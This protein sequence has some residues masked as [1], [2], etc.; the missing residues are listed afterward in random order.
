MKFRQLVAEKTSLP[1]GV[2]PSSYQ[3]I[4]NIMVMKFLKASEEEK[5]I[6]SSS[7]LELYPYIKTVCE[8]KGI[9]GEFRQPSVIKLAGNGTET[10]HKEHG[11]SYNL[12]VSKIMFSKGNHFERQ[13]IAKKAKKNEV[14][15]DMFAGIGYFSLGMKK[16]GKVYA[17][18]KNPVAFNYLQQN[19]RINKISNVEAINKDCREVNLDGIADRIIMGYFPHTERFLPFALRFLKNRGII[20]FH[21]TYLESDLWHKP[22]E[23]LK[24]LGKIR[25]LEK[26]KVK[27]VAPRCWHV[28][29][30][31]EVEK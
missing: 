30:D 13:R 25:I 5:R 28:V 22:L 1:R 23:Q 12:D 3:I 20:H 9:E 19:I 14:I 21:N 7:V 15:I 6:I 31:V 24:I 18:E 8:I 17:L 26:K 27:S 29:M 11:I 16:A 10:I 2:I 4:G